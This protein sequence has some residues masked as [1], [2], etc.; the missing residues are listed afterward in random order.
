MTIKHPIVSVDWLNNNLEAS[1]LIVLDATM[2]KV[3]D[4]SSEQSTIQIPS[5]RFFDIKN[6][7]SNT[8]NPFPN[9]VPSEEQFSTEA[10]KLGINKDSAIVVYDAKGIYSSARVWWL[11]KAFGHDNIAVLN[12]GLP[13]W[14]KANY[15]TESK[16]NKEFELGDFVANYNPEYFKFFDDIQN[17]IYNKNDLILDAR[18]ADRFNG[19]VEEPREG[20]RSGHIP[21]SKSLPYS[22]LFDENKLK[23][24]DELT[25]IFNTFNS[26]EKNLI[27]SCGSGITACILALGADLAG[28]KNLSIYDGSWTEYGSL[29]NKDDME[30]T[31]QW[32]K[33]ELVAYILLYAS[34]SDLIESN[35]EKNIIISK[36]DM[37]TFQR[38]HDEFDGDNDYQSIQKII[39]GLKAHN[40]TKIDID[41]L[42]ADI[43]LLFFADG[44]FN[45]SERTM[46][47]LLKK[48]LKV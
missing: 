15:K 42:F 16:Q 10:Q 17:S 6:T 31:T 30:S 48:L 39:A 46:Y 18:S 7:F 2:K 36:V 25:S 13:E 45:V 26:T 40:Y 41:L 21:N 44:N 14:L 3:T 12:G 34:Q 29:T 23:S 4:S 38:I 28:Y 27:F 19:L 47:K 24:D 35:K 43:K 32:A 33:D 22:E 9:A 5:A 37:N 20:L 8:S 1:N 11:F